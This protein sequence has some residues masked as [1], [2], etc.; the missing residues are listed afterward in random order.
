MMEKRALFLRHLSAIS[1][2]ASTCVQDLAGMDDPC[3]PCHIMG[4]GVLSVAT[5]VTPVSGPPAV[6]DSFVAECPLAEPASLVTPSSRG[7]TRDAEAREILCA[8][9]RPAIKHR[10]EKTLL[11]A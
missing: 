5:S 8:L 6:A 10:R 1:L 4:Q 3:P 2:M 11:M 9:S 7:A